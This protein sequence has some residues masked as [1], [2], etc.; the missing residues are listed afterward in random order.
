MENNCFSHKFSSGI[1][2]VP[3]YGF[4]RS[5]GTIQT[6]SVPLGQTCYAVSSKIVSCFKC[7]FCGKSYVANED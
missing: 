7:R 2:L 3:V 6:E 1:I 5:D 4:I